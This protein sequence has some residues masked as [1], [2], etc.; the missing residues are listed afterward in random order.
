MLR[1]LH[2]RRLVGDL[3][4]LAA[5]FFL[6]DFNFRQVI[7]TDHPN[8]KNKPNHYSVCTHGTSTFTF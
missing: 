6:W 1:Y 5:H 4:F 3:F 8:N 2:A 7:Q